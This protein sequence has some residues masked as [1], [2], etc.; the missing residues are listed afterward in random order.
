MLGMQL[1]THQIGT[2]LLC[3]HTFEH[4]RCLKTSSIMLGSI[5]GRII[6]SYCKQRCM[7]L[8]KVDRTV[9]AAVEYSYLTRLLL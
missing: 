2:G 9:D 1:V 4:N 8:K 6:M 3:W 7:P 5:I